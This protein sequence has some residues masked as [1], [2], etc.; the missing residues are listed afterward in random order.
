MTVRLG[1]FI[2]HEQ[3]LFKIP[4]TNLTGG[5]PMMKRSFLVFAV[6][7]ALTVAV[8]AASTSGPKA[9]T[10]GDFAVRVSKALGK[11]TPNRD[12]AVA[13]LKSAGVDLGKDMS[14]TLTERD[15]ARILS[16]LG[17]KSTSRT[18]DRQLTTSKA[19]Q[20][21]GAISQSSVASAAVS[22]AALPTACLNESNRGACQNCCKVTFGCTD[23]NAPCDFSA[24]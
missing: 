6:C 22:P 9:V 8:F 23:P 4:R 19:D 18:P 13:N 15:A 16:D 21:I 20:L 14:A 17:I 2:C 5:S 12:A 10:V 3:D 7:A 24:T 1:V 11:A